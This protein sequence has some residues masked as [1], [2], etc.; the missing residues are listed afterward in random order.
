MRGSDLLRLCLLSVFTAVFSLAGCSSE[1]PAGKAAA[2]KDT[3]AAS[4]SVSFSKAAG[5][6]RAQYANDLER[7][8][9]LTDRINRAC[10]RSYVV[11]LGGDNSA[12]GGGVVS[13]DY[14]AFDKLSDDGAAVLIVEAIAAG[15]R[16]IS[17][18]QM[19]TQVNIERE[20]LESDEAVGGYVARA[21]FSSDGFTEWLG[22]RTLSA[23]N[24]QQNSVPEKVRI[25]AFMRGYS[26]EHYSKKER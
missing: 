1:E 25:A 2:A 4:N 5:V 8:S 14:A 6:E 13:V 7:L 17:Q 9:R 22:A 12:A 15:S 16:S 21:G 26:S 10:R 3:A 23:G 11:V 24:R 20:I 18:M 19:Q